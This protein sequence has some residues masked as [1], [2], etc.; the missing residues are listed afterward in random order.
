MKEARKRKAKASERERA[1]IEAWELQF[2][3]GAQT[4]DG[5]RKFTKAL[6]NIVMKYPDDIEAKALLGHETMGTSAWAPSC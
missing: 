4:A 1:Y 6:E 2:A 3:E 5:R